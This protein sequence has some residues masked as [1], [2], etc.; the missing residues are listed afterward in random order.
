MA[1]SAIFGS[2]MT[3]RPAERADHAKRAAA[4]TSASLK[5]HEN[6]S[7]SMRFRNTKKNNASPVTAYLSSRGP[8]GDRQA[9]GDHLGIG[10]TNQHTGKLIFLHGDKRQT[11]AAG[12]TEIPR[13]QWQHVVLVRDGASVRAYL[14]GQLELETTA[15]A[16]FP[17]A[18]DQ[19]FF[20]GRSDN[21]SNW[22]GRLDEIA[23]FPRALETD[24]VSK[25]WIRS[26]P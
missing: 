12:K 13:W 26:E 25:L 21:D 7:V 19:C 16:N 24:A 6:W 20:G 4:Q 2:A 11:V 23:V 14:N 10:G 9:S 1:A 22:E 5:Q 18:F 17:A 15:P 3:S 8:K